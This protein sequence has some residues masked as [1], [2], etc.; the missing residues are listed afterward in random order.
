MAGGTASV[1]LDELMRL[2]QQPAGQMGA[3][4]LAILVVGG[5]LWGLVRLTSG[6]RRYRGRTGRRAV[7]S[8]SSPAGATAQ[9]QAELQAPVYDIRPAFTGPDDG[10]IVHEVDPLEEAQIF[11]S[12]GHY[13]A[14]ANILHW[15][16]QNFPK[17]LDATHQLL[18]LYLEL[19]D[20]QHYASVL[21]T[22]VKHHGLDQAADAIT[23]GVMQFPQNLL[24]QR[25]AQ[26]AEGVDRAALEE[27]RAALAEEVEVQPEPAQE[28]VVPFKPAASGPPRKT[29]EAA[30]IP[31]VQEAVLLVDFTPSVGA[32]DPLEQLALSGFSTSEQAEQRGSG[33]QRESSSLRDLHWRLLKEP[34]QVDHYVQLLTRYHRL[35]STDDY[36]R[37]LWRLFWVMGHR[38]EGLRKRML[39]YGL[40]LGRH[41][42]LN[43]LVKVQLSELTLTQLADR[44]GLD[45][46]AELDAQEDLALVLA[47]GVREE[48]PSREGTVEEKLLA[49]V[50][51]MVEFGQAEGAIETLERALFNDPAQANLY[52]VLLD[53]YIHSR[54]R[55]RFES[56]Q[57]QILGSEIQPPLDVIL[58]IVDAG[59]RM[60]SEA[61]RTGT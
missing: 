8:H 51:D 5:V 49:N 20:E 16:I 58:K 32:L 59:K 31:S 17:D 33:A 15:H 7:L 10:T 52:P 19:D 40:K 39:I 55:D 26:E 36:A 54:S 45:P 34:L 46:A 21:K 14:A 1:N 43:G 4:F 60:E 47:E 11:I 12:Y 3:S 25:L 41:P 30:R 37:V 56:F 18:A 27:L 35:A 50:H 13:D 48:Q 22:H 53:L 57:R 24:V 29:R 2:L 38:G 44:L 61:L 42:T 23:N 28:T 6:R 9:G